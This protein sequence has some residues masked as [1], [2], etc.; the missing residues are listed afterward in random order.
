MEPVE[1]QHEKAEYI[2]KQHETI[3]RCA[4]DD[5]LE[6]CGLMRLPK[7]ADGKYWHV[8][9]TVFGNDGAKWTIVAVG[10]WNGDPSKARNLVVENYIGT[11]RRVTAHE[12]SHK[13]SLVNRIRKFVDENENSDALVDWDELLGIADKLEGEDE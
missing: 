11:V 4:S 5:E 1:L 7:D 9:E 8:G 2:S 10:D 3:L 6:K 13:L 12:F